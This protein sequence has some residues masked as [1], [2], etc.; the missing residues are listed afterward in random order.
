M[1]MSMTVAVSAVKTAWAWTVTEACW[2]VH[3][4]VAHPICS[5]LN[6]AAALLRLIDAPVWAT[7]VE[8]ASD[9]VHDGTVPVGSAPRNVDRTA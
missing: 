7:H 3:G 6:V 1:T 9:L 4:C 5:V 8:A 2:L